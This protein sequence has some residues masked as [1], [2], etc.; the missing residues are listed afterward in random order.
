MRTCVCV[1]VCVCVFV[2]VCVRAC[3]CVCACLSVCLSVCLSACAPVD[4]FL[5]SGIFRFLPPLLVCLSV[6]PS[7]FPLVFEPSRTHELACLVSFCLLLFVYIP[8]K[9]FHRALAQHHRSSD[10]PP[11]AHLTPALYALTPRH[12]P[13]AAAQA[14]A[15]GG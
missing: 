10:F 7:L 12:L 4:S 14:F 9:S 2:C 11:C 15:P 5:F 1:C 6:C 3:V 8:P 13:V